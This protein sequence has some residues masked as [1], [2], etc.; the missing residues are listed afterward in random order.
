MRELPAFGVTTLL[1]LLLVVATAAAVRAGYL[2]AATDSGALRSALVV[3]APHAEAT[4]QDKL[5][6]SLVNQHGFKGAAPLSDGEEVTAHIAPGYPWLVSFMA[7]F[8]DNPAQAMRW[9]QCV[10]GTLTAACYFLFARRAFFSN[11]IGFVAG[12]LC[13]VYPFWVFDCAEIADGALV[14]FLLAATLAVGTRGSQVGGAFT[15]LLF[16][17]LLAGL[18]LVRAALLPFAILGLLWFLWRCRLFRWGWFAALLALLGF[19][20]GLAPWCVRNYRAFG[21]PLPVI[22]SA[23]LHLW[24]GNNSSAT[25]AGLDEQTLRQSFTEERRGQLLEEDN[26]ARRYGSLGRDVVSEIQRDPLAA[27]GNRLSAAQSFLLGQQWL[28]QRRLGIIEAGDDVAEPPE[29][30]RDNFE[31]LLA[32]SLV[33]LLTLAVLGWRWSY[34]C[35][36]HARLATLA[37]LW[38]P[39]PYVMTHAGFLSGPRLPLDGVLLCFAAYALCS[40]LPG[41]ARVPDAPVTVA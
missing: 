2:V 38:L 32:S 15:S 19:G 31:L 4:E 7:R 23:Y 6:Q 36:W 26:Q 3:Q 35:A 10:L 1:G 41:R 8:T 24:M 28:A 37:A 17:L 25:G 29:W 22:S 30:L 21:T 13:A 27:V 5:V 11:G 9:L 33:L 12:L 40:W 18:A 20:N 34:A 14:S 16:G 39:L